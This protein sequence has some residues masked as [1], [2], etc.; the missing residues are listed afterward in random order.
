[1]N[2]WCLSFVESDARQSRQGSEQKNS[3]IRLQTEP[4]VESGPKFC[5]VMMLGRV[6]CDG[7]HVL[8]GKIDSDTSPL[9]ERA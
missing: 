6:V 1:M 9:S 3:L 2:Q 4:R 8:E 5:R 7:V